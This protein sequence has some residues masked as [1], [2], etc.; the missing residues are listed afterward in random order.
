MTPSSY[1]KPSGDSLT[2]VDGGGIDE[3]RRRSGFTSATTLLVLAATLLVVC[4]VLSLSNKQGL[5]PAAF[6]VELEGSSLHAAAR[7][8][9]FSECT[10]SQCDHHSAPYTCLFHNGGPHGGCSAS[11]WTPE[12]CTE[13]CS[14]SGCDSL[15]VP[16]G[17]S[18]CSEKSCPTEWCSIGQLCGPDVP[19]QCTEGSGRFGCSDDPYHWVLY[20]C[21]CCDTT[22]CQ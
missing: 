4:G 21:E 3:S 15:K 13:S 6:T 17:T 5:Q 9:T 8:C 20:G 2:V 16:K 12:S 1:Q 10:S 14:L 19:Y 18:T 11:E 22:T 7:A